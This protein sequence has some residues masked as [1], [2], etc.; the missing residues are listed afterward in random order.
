MANSQVATII[1][2]QKG[3]N[4]RFK[5][6][7]VSLF[8]ASST[9]ALAV[10]A[11]WWGLSVEFVNDGGFWLVGLASVLAIA[12]VVQWV[13]PLYEE[14]HM[15]KEGGVWIILASTWVP[16][17]IVGLGVA[18]QLA[19]R[20][21]V[22]AWANFL[23]PIAAM[24]PVIACVVMIIINAYKWWELAH[25]E[26][27]DAGLIKYDQNL[28]EKVWICHECGKESYYLDEEG[29]AFCPTRCSDCVEGDK[30]SY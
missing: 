5:S 7:L 23:L 30:Y 6:M 17:L 24:V 11:L 26:A 25:R 20:W 8:V 15:D 2:W 18:S 1:K 22:E 4:M 13:A 14:T 29:R 16:S 19:G 10:L 12:S 27:Q 21:D 28:V 9:L 3:W